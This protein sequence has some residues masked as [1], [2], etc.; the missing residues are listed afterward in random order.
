M[1][2][3]AVKVTNNTFV[4]SLKSMMSIQN[5]KHYSKESICMSSMILIKL[6]IIIKPRLLIN[7]VLNCIYRL[8]YRKNSPYRKS[9]LNN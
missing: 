1:L 3:I 4:N 9:I 8:Y 7:G 5:A 6:Y 2:F